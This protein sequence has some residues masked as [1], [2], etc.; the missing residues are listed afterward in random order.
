MKKVYDMLGVPY[1]K[2]IDCLIVYPDQDSAEELD[3]STEEAIKK[4]PVNGYINFYKM[5]VKL[6][7]VI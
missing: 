7:E 2:V 1:C 6:P 4:A 3:L 5:G